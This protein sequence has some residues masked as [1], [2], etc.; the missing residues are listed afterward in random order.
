MKQFRLPRLKRAAHL[1]RKSGRALIIRDG[2]LLAFHRKRY[3]RATGQWIEYYSIPGGGVDTDETAAEATIR[4]LG[5]EMGVEIVLDTHVA[6][7]TAPFFEHDLYTAHIVSGE[8]RLMSDS[9]E[10]MKMSERNQFI[11][12][13]VPISELSEANMRYYADY[14]PL[15][16]DIARG[17]TPVNP[18]QLRLR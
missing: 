16:Q 18:V 12:A 2:K 8:P 1:R 3:S 4:E 13:W 14:L 7:G 9:E 6:H 10:A 5:E 15:I 17:K 11:V